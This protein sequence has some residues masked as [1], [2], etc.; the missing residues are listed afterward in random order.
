MSNAT[1]RDHQPASTFKPIVFASALENEST[2]QDGRRI[3]A[4]TRYDGTSGRPV[5]GGDTPFAPQN[6]DDYSYGEV[7]VQEAMNKSI[8]SVFA[9]MI[10]D[11]GPAKAKKTAL[12]LGMKDSDGFVEQPA[13]TLGTMGAS[14][15]DMAGVYATL[16]NHGKKVTPT[17]VKSAEHEHRAVRPADPIGPQA[18]SRQTADTVTSVLTGVVANGS[19]LAAYSPAYQAA[20]K[21]GTSE[22]NKSAWFAG[23]TP[24]LVTVVALFGEDAEKG[25][26]VSLTGTANSGRASAAA[27]RPASGRTTPW[28][29]WAAAPTR[30]DL[31]ALE[32]YDPGP[33]PTAQPS[34]S[35]PPPSSRPSPS[36]DPAEPSRTPSSSASSTTPAPQSPSADPPTP[37]PPTPSPS[38]RPRAPASPA[39]DRARSRARTAAAG[40]R[41]PGSSPRGRSGRM[42]GRPARPP[43]H[44]Q[45]VPEPRRLSPASAARTRRPCR[46][47]AASRPTGA[48]A[49]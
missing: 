8:N 23:Y 29:P 11:V 5:K 38:P 37:T 17:I 47:T 46:S 43:P 10:V 48:P 32:S 7:T 31:E 4:N 1:R 40:T 12:A 28:T 24:E 14:T 42:R 41:P 6:L 36:D 34:R 25:T 15:W 9:Q 20:G 30:F 39:A 18:V 22:N 26:Q 13:M 21:T 2:T 45:P 49:G 27:S 19:G 3:G 33:K 16:D 44:P 35:T